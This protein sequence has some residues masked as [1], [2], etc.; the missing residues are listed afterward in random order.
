MYPEVPAMWEAMGKQITIQFVLRPK[1]R[2]YLKINL[3]PKR[4]SKMAQVA[5]HLPHKYKAQ[6]STPSATRK[7]KKNSKACHYTFVK[8]HRMYPQNEP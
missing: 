3:K 8:T 4:A 1:A 6:S 7:K 2:P 5:E